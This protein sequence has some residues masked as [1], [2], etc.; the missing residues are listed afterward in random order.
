MYSSHSKSNCERRHLG[1]A[2]GQ[3]MSCPFISVW[4]SNVSAPVQRLTFGSHYTFGSPSTISMDTM[5]K[6]FA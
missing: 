1:G 6:S 4:S 3:R 2:L 5:R